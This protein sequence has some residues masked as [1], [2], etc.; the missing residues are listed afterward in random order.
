[1]SLPEDYTSYP[2]RAYGMDQDRYAWRPDAARRKVQWPGERLVAGLIVVPVED[3]ALKPSG[4]PFMHPGAATNPYPDLRNFTARDYGNRVG[5]FRILDTLKANGL[6]ATVPVSTS[7]L[8]TRRYLVDQILADGHEIAAYGLD[9]DHIHFGALDQAT[10][11]AWIEQTRAAFDAIDL[12]PRAWMSPARQQSFATLDLIAKAGFDVCLDWEQ[13][14]V[15][16]AMTTSGGPVS[17]V[18]VS[19]ELDDRALM[20]DRRHDE[21]S[22]SDQILA[23]F[24]YLKER[25]PVEGG[26]VLGFT[27]TP[28]VSGQPSRTWALRKVLEAL[29]A[30]GALWNAG[31]SA[32]A[33]AVK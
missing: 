10:E 7:L 9:T 15:P 5:V 26:Q 24:D 25:Y 1:M 31:A 32:I 33:D 13:D 27:L 20:I 12:H 17:A 29:G 18:P 2:R 19:M 8:Q 11:A 28:F 3:F 22:W 14:S 21:M 6:T 16:V 4:K 30:D 23:A